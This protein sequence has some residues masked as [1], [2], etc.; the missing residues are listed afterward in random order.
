[1]TTARTIV[2]T[3]ALLLLQPNAGHAEEFGMGS[4]TFPNSGSM[5]AQ[6]AFLDGVM[7][8]HSFMFDGASKEDSKALLSY[9]RER[10]ASLEV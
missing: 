9:V 10:S 1:M 3:F 5:Q 4:I 8:L 7:A 2:C 6:A